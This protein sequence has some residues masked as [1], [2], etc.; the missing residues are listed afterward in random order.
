MFLS[1]LN[2]TC[3]FPVRSPYKFPI[4]SFAEICPVV[5][6]LIHVELRTERHDE[7]N[8]RFSRLCEGTKDEK[9]ETRPRRFPVRQAV[10]DQLFVFTA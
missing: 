1:D 6:P 10:E 8:R 7:A 4:S 9:P 5:S 2:K 3:S